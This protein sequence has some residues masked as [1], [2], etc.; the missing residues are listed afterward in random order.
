[1]KHETYFPDKVRW[2]LCKR[3]NE[4]KLPHRICIEHHDI[5]AM[6]EEDWRELN[7]KETIS[8]KQTDN[9]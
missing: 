3:C 6:R 2:Q 8:F 1:L 5:C 7:K 4:P 9:K